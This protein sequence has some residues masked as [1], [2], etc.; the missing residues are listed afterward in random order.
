MGSLGKEKTWE[1]R[2]ERGGRV[3]GPR[4][5]TPSVVVS[6]EGLSRR[7][8]S[9]WGHTSLLPGTRE[10]G[11]RLV[12]QEEDLDAGYRLRRGVVT[13]PLPLLSPSQDRPSPFLPVSPFET[14]AGVSPSRYRPPTGREVTDR[15]TRPYSHTSPPEGSGWVGSVDERVPLVGVT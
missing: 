3:G 2:V 13:D 14:G 6:R 5:S 8:W 7:T 1:E 15:P 9:P 4:P 11:R 10:T 12:V